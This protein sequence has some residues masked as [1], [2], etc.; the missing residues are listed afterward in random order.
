MKTAVNSRRPLVIFL[1][2]I[3]CLASQALAAPVFT[4]T[5]DWQVRFQRGADLPARAMAGFGADAT[6]DGDKMNLDADVGDAGAESKISVPSRTARNATARVS[7]SRPFSLE[8]GENGWFV[9]LTG[10]LTGMLSANQTAGAGLNPRAGVEAWARIINSTGGEEIRIAWTPLEVTDR[11]DNINI[12]ANHAL[13]T[14]WDRRNLDDGG[15]TVEGFLRTYAHLGGTANLNVR[16]YAKSEFFDGFKVSVG[17]EAA[18]VNMGNDAPGAVPEP[19]TFLLVAA[20]LLVASLML[21][22]RSPA[23]VRSRSEF[24]ARRRQDPRL[25]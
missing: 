21:R 14:N 5:D 18:P 16:G 24:S 8:G 10:V 15:Y 12:D 19:G 23:I 11:G 22:R 25:A 4:W 13:Y 20:A 17:A 1:G 3:I 9:T 7:F 2:G 6:A